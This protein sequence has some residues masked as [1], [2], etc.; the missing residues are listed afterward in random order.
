MSSK[1]IVKEFALS[2]TSE[3]IDWGVRPINARDVSIDAP[4]GSHIYN[5]YARIPSDSPLFRLIEEGLV[6]DVIGGDITYV[7]DD[8]WIG[9]D[10]C[11]FCDVWPLSVEYLAAET[12]K[13]RAAGEK[14][15]VWNIEKIV[16]ETLNLCARIA[17]ANRSAEALA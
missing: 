14:P 6:E 3:G 4:K 10:T 5:G 17:L 13:V 11:H 9:F 1:N 12:E 7:G 2:G 16:E 8:G 15:F